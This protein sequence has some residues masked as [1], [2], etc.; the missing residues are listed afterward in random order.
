MDLHSSLTRRRWLQSAGA[1]VGAPALLAAQPSST[2]ELSLSVAP[3]EEIVRIPGDFT[4]LS[5]ESAQL[6]DPEFFASSNRALVGFVR[7][8][9]A[10]GMLRIGGNTSEFTQW[11]SSG[12]PASAGAVGPDTGGELHRKTPVTPE[13]VRNLAAFVK[14][15]GW[16]LIYGLNLGGGTPE[17]AAAEGQ[18]VCEAAGDALWAL[19]IGNE[20]DLFN[21]NGLR[22]RDW[23]FDDYLSQWLEFAGAIRKRVPHAPFAA[24]DVAYNVKWTAAFAKKAKDQVIALTGH[25]YAMGPP[26]N[27][28]M[29]IARLLKPTTSLLRDVPIIMQAS[30]SSGLPYRMAEGNSCYNGGKAGVSD[31]FASALW[32]GDYMLYV[33]QA[34]YC[35]VNLHGGGNGYYTPVAGGMEQGFAARPEYYGMLLAGQFAGSTMVTTNLAEQ[36]LN[37]TAYAAKGEGGLRIAVFNKEEKQGLRLDVA[38]SVSSGRASIWRLAAPAVDAKSGVTLAGAA[39]GGAGAWKPAKEEDAKL[40]HGRLRVEMPAASAVLIW[41]R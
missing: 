30:H 12:A 2:P 19:Q 31:T 13:A 15:C 21:R 22:P 27:P 1:F 28:A 29:N 41:L 37:V 14:A 33:A 3:S 40:R 23:S 26:T 25:Y 11:S 38:P 6:A 16:R 5:Y 17:Q 8:L 24:P 20:P 18:A 39:V 4:G 7:R 9:G 34:G 32:V 10:K 35:G 36:G